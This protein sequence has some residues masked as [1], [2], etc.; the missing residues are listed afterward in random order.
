MRVS[1]LLILMTMTSASGAQTP[2][3]APPGQSAPAGDVENGKK[4]FTSYGCYQCHNYAANG[5]AAGPRL[6]PNP[7]PFQAFVLLV[8]KPLDQMPPYTAKIVSNKE[9]ADIYAF[10][11][12]IPAPPAADSILILKP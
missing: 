8:R 6:A 1:V 11:L 9:L 10:L 12:T 7:L 5:G 3:A 2:G 4:I